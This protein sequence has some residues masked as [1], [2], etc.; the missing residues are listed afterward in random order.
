MIMCVLLC[1]PVSIRIYYQ[2][3]VLFLVKHYYGIGDFFGNCL[4]N[5]WDFVRGFLEIC[6]KFVGHWCNTSSNEIS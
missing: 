4:E 5:C 2:Q 3:G 6:W 1:Y